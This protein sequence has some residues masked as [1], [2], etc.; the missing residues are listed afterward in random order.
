MELSYEKCKEH[1]IIVL[2][3]NKIPP[4]PSDHLIDHLRSQ[5]EIIEAIFLLLNNWR[6]TI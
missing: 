3:L 2:L 5:I 6:Q 1:K 4:Q